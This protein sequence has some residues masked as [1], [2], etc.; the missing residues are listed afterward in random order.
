[1]DAEQFLPIYIE[2]DGSGNGWLNCELRQTS[3][4]HVRACREACVH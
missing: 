2:T 4:T 3:C 1:M